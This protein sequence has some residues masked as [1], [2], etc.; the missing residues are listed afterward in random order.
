MLRKAA[1]QA[2]KDTAYSATEAGKGIEEL[3]KAG[4]STADILGGGLKGALSLA[5]AG[6]L[7]VGEAAE[8]AATAMT[9]FNL[10][11]NQV[12]HVADL[13]A[14]GAGKAQGSVHDMGYALKAGGLVASQMGLSIEDT[15]G[16]LAAFASAGLIGSDSGTSFKS[17]LQA[18][19]NP[20]SKSAKV[21]K[22]LGLNVY[23]AQ[24][25]FVGLTQL[26]GQL[27]ARMQGLTQA[28]RDQAM[29]QIFG[30]DGIR[31]ATVLYKQGAERDQR[32]DQQDERRR[33]CGGDRGT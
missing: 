29:A 4:I 28:Q 8:T 21:M 17:M 20:S 12:G 9:Q 18:L 24:G 30:S 3:S 10:K 1:L 32:L 13:L 19:Q 14:A 26:A 23:D 15:T 31:A 5:A 25:Q 6:Q 27:Q 7:D 22:E 11:G 16:A 33:L 2:G